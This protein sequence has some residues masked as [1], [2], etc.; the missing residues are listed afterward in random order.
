MFNRSE[1]EMA[2]EHAKIYEQIR[3]ETLGELE[4]QAKT[5]KKATK[6][7]HVKLEEILTDVINEWDIRGYA[8]LLHSDKIYGVSISSRLAFDVETGI[9]YKY[10]SE[11]EF[12]GYSWNGDD[13]YRP[14]YKTVITYQEQVGQIEINNSDYD[15][16]M[17][18]S[19]ACHIINEFQDLGLLRNRYRK[20][21]DLPKSN[22]IV[23]LSKLDEQHQ[24][25][26]KK[27]V[28]YIL[29]IIN[30]PN[31]YYLD[32][33]PTTCPDYLKGKQEYDDCTPADLKFLERYM[34]MHKFNE[35]ILSTIR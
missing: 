9:L 1:M 10:D 24:K 14:Y 2:R 31:D 34:K 5:T 3:Q 21:D 19:L 4:P 15:D 25:S 16:E 22:G 35:Q 11:Q 27:T 29:A 13:E 7:D 8:S 18:E 12:V 23:D 28:S 6:I 17:L 32:R 30:S 33:T 20:F 26:Y